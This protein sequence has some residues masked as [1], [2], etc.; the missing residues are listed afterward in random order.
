MLDEV[1]DVIQR[2]GTMM[3]VI[4]AVSLVTAAF[5]GER[6]YVLWVSLR[7]NMD[8]FVDQLIDFLDQQQMSRALELCTA[9]ERHPFG[10]VAKAGLLKA[11]MPDREIQR[12]MEAAAL[13][14]YPIVTRRVGYLS[15][16]ANVATLMG[17]LGTVF[18]LIEAFRGVSEA[19]AAAKQEILSKG[20][21][22]AM[23]TT[24]FGL[25]IAIVAVVASAILQ[26]RQ[27]RLIAE[28]EAKATD[29]LNYLA[30]R[31]RTAAKRAG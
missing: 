27:G 24:A 4:L 2:G 12:A 30:E 22:M 29:L 25:I 19:D 8:H 6:V 16:L 5:I 31:S 21:A 28:I 15:M 14:A 9:H 3:W 10:N 18:G 13:R 7:L 20:I 1:F 26:S 23:S 17:L 11:N